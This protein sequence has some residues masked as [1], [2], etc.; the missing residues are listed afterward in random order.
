MATN[1]VQFYLN[2]FARNSHKLNYPPPPSS[3]PYPSHPFMN[4]IQGKLAYFPSF[5]LHI[6]HITPP[7][8]PWIPHSFPT[9]LDP[10]EF[11]YP[12]HHHAPPLS[13][14]LVTMYPS[15]ILKKLREFFSNSSHPQPTNPPLYQKQWA[16]MT[17]TTAQ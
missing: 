10:Q 5:S 8:R 7:C 9:C 2:N 3:P 6:R 4:V 14:I 12:I 17:T 15:T 13:P 11:L 16:T 1:Q